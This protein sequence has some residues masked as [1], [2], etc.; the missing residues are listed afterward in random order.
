[1][2]IPTAIA[3]SMPALAADDAPQRVVS[4]NL[5][6]DQLA[7]LVAGPDQLVSV[8]A[9]AQDP[10]NS[11]MADEAQR[12]P[13]NHGRAE[14]IHL[15]Q[16]DQVIA[17]RFSA[18]ATVAMLRRLEIPVAVFEPA[19]SLDDVRDNLRRMGEVL[20]RPDRADALIRAFDQRL[21]ALRA[22]GRERPA[23][24][25]AL[26]FPNGYTRGD[27]TL[28]GAI[29]EAAGFDNI[30]SDLGV[31]R[32]GHLPLEQLVLASP[33][34][35]ITGSRGPGYS[36]AEA[37]MRHPVLDEI[38]PAGVQRGLGNADWVCGIPQVLDAIERMAE[39]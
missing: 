9:L 30:A 15:L 10:A 38:A 23:T 1:M 19:T 26:Y 36:R 39:L 13:A 7:M 35:I 32:G 21:T 4:M 11:A 12:Y 25:V 2:L 20:G 29:V 33:E 17:G 3:M 27:G 6:T 14:E 34:R 31:E 37:V 5:C 22:A 18:G 24:D 16:P 8:L 28:I